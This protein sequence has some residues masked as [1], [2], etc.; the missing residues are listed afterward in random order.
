ME[1]R[2]ITK[3]HNCPYRLSV[4]QGAVSENHFHRHLELV[5][6]LRGGIT[7]MAGKTACTL[8]PRDFIFA[9]PYEIHAISQ[10]AEDTN[11]IV[12]EIET[13]SFQPLFSSDPLPFFRW[14]ETYNNRSQQI[15]REV[16]QANRR[17]STEAINQE[18]SWLAKI[19]Q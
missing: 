6:V 5:L 17:I 15:Y 1:F 19:H 14:D 3:E 7:Y 4:R 12:L 13:Q 8:G 16:K 2:L 10:V 11:L 9:N 18:P